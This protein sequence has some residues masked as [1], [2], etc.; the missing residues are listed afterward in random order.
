MSLCECG[1]GLLAPIAK[2]TA[3]RLGHVKGRPVRFRKGHWARTNGNKGENNPSWSG[4]KIKHSAGYVMALRPDHPRANKGGYVMEH[5]LIAESA[6]A[7]LLPRGAE[8]HHVNGIRDDNRN[9]NLVVCQDRAYHQL[10]HLR[11]RAI[12][13][14]GD[15]QARRCLF[16]GQWSRDL[17]IAKQGQTFHPFCVNEYNRAYEK[18]R[19]CRYVRGR[20]GS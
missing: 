8:V 2:M 20:G 3:K 14:C 4:G 18:K 17:K 15:A 9:S 10:L 7:M 6:M 11:Q 1:C 16:C 13:G 12:C 5:I 19:A